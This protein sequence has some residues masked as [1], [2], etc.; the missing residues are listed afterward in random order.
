MCNIILENDFKR[1][2]LIEIIFYVKYI[3]MFCKSIRKYRKV[4]WER[5]NI[6]EGDWGV[7]EFI[8]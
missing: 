8:I 3:V 7:R 4:E 2:S 1:V 6:R 5:V